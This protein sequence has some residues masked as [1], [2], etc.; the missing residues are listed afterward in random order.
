MVCYTY[1]VWCVYIKNIFICMYA[2]CVYVSI[3]CIEGETNSWRE[4][5]REMEKLDGY[6]PTLLTMVTSEGRLEGGLSHP[7]YT[8]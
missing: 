1:T 4:S 8:F 6:L 5:G 7:V 3:F 2:M